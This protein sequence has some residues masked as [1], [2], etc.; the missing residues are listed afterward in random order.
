M[1]SDQLRGADESML[2]FLKLAKL[3][4]HQYVIT[5]PATSM[6]LVAISMYVDVSSDDVSC[7]IIEI[8]NMMLPRMLDVR[9][10]TQLCG[11]YLSMPW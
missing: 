11:A 7:A 4:Y 1:E 6:T 9:I 5:I 8:R 3:S 2:L 10:A